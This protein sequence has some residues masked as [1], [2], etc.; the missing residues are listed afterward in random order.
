MERPGDGSLENIIPALSFQ[1]QIEKTK[2]DG[3]PLEKGECIF[4]RMDNL[5]GFDFLLKDGLA[6]S[7]DIFC[8]QRFIFYDNDIHSPISD[9]E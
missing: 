8:N 2:I 7:L 5:N 6:E 3:P 9:E 1:I 4:L